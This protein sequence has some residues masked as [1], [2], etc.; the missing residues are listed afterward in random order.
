MATANFSIQPEDGWV[1]VTDDAVSFIRIRGYPSSQ[2][3]YVTTGETT[4]A[5]T[6]RGYRID[7]E[8]FWCDV[9]ILD[10]FYVRVVN[11]KPDIDYR[12]DVFYNGYTPPP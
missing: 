6:V 1:E 3:Y 10:N 11:S 12:I 4:P 2:A 9:P 5:D 7:C 8:E